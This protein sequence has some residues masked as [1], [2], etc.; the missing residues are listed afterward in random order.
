MQ[1]NPSVSVIVINYNGINDTRECLSSLI[2][3]TYSNF[4]ILVIDNGSKN[5]QAI[6]LQNE[7]KDSRIKILRSQ[8]NLGFAGGNNLGIEQSQTDFVVLLNND[9]TVEPMWLDELVK[10]A[11]TDDQIGA[12]QPKL[13]SY[14]NKE[15]FEYAGAVGGF[16]DKLGYPY[17]R[18]RIG[19]ALEKDEG[20]YDTNTE[21]FWASGSCIMLRKKILTEVGL[22][23]T[24]FFFHHEEIDLCWRIKNA[25]YK[26]MSAPKSVVYHK[27]MGS[28]KEI[29]P[30]KVYYVHRNNLLLLARNLSFKRLI[31]TLPIRILMD[32]FSCFYYFFKGQIFYI[33]AVFKA[34]Y[35]FLPML[36]KTISER[37]A[38]EKN[39]QYPAEKELRPVSIFIKYFLLNKRRFSE[40]ISNN[41][42]PIIEYKDVLPDNVIERSNKQTLSLLTSP[43]LLI[44]LIVTVVMMIW[45]HNGSMIATGEEG[46]PFF[47]P[48][49]I[50]KVYNSVWYDTG[51]GYPMPVVQP[52]VPLLFVAAELNKVLPSFAVQGLI[53]WFIAF[54]GM[55]GMYHLAK[56]ILNNRSMALI[57]SLFYFFNLFSMVQIWQR[58]L[59]T[60]MATWSLLPWFLY[61]WI[62]LLK[63]GK[64]RHLLLFSLISIPYSYAFGQPADLFALWLPAI[65]YG[66]Y[67]FISRHKERV[68]ISIRSLAGVTAWA[69]I[70][71]WWLYPYWKV[72]QDS[73]SI[74]SGNANYDSLRGISANFSLST[75]I[76]LRQ[77]FF[78]STEY[79]NGRYAHLVF[80]LLAWTVVLVVAFG[81]WSFRKNKLWLYLILC[82]F[83]AIIICKGT[84]PPYGEQ[85]YTWL[86]ANIPQTQTLRNPTEKYGVALLIP[87]ALFFA[88][89]IGY[90]ARKGNAIPLYKIGA[91]AILFATCVVLVWPMW[92]GSVFSATRINTMITVPQDYVEINKLINKDKSDVRLLTIPLVLG[93]GVHYNWETGSYDGLEPSEFLFDKPTISKILRTKY[94]DE[95]YENTIQ[96]IGTP[97]FITNLNELNVKYVILHKDVPWFT[98]Q[99]L[100]TLEIYT[101]IEKMKETDHLIL[102]RNN[103][104]HSAS[105]ITLEGKNTPDYSVA[106]LSPTKYS[107]QVVNATEPY[108]LIFK[109]TFSDHWQATI[110]RK[111]LDNHKIIY[112]YANVWQSSQKGS[113]RIDIEFK[114]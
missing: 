93:D 76:T 84:N 80:A 58:M 24:L 3:S 17:C 54:S 103:T 105:R 52:R 63:E 29:L 11:I 102:Y 19:F 53:Y 75:L 12:L 95:K 65:V 55:L 37:R 108:S 48:A 68:K 88:A 10:V 27:G 85:L 2:L 50:L 91:G 40:I 8:E 62:Q 71:I 86:F 28:S 22:L 67:Q 70:N 61:L 96:N 69:G 66:I 36:N 14:K 107:I 7:F 73:F 60:G 104:N 81:V 89:G 113:Y 20:Q 87:Y 83:L 13:R 98:K 101:E 25:N 56:K 57:A 78:F 94:F 97:V 79:F 35:D 74:V 106:Q 5:D 43:T 9:T 82:L 18:G 4:Q 49:R 64:L 21:I 42:V 51:T 33:P 31:I 77:N 109:N 47:E 45:F 6:I 41:P 112:D 15:Y 110:D 39:K 59:L 16:I 90:I 30:K 114:I 34:I 100:E 46:L 38:S 111:N 72:G 26:I 44:F 1:Q 99:Q 32:I 92:R 23:P